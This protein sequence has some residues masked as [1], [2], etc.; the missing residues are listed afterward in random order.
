MPV[1]VLESF[2]E[3]PN[4][5]CYSHRTSVANVEDLRK[6]EQAIAVFRSKLPVAPEEDEYLP[7]TRR[8]LTEEE[9]VTLVEALKSGII[10]PVKGGVNEQ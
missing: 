1:L 4:G 8:K 6:I 7:L 10:K 2:H 3:S 9:R 5:T